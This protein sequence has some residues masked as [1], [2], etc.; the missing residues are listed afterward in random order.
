MAQKTLPYLGR[1]RGIWQR[2]EWAVCLPSVGQLE[3]SKLR[4]FQPRKPFEFTDNKSGLADSDRTIT[5]SC[6]LWFLL[7]I[8]FDLQL[9]PA[10]DQLGAERGADDVVQSKKQISLVLCVNKAELFC[11][12]GNDST[13]GVGD[14][15]GH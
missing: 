7:K 3:K 4:P 8:N 1:Q 12:E 11:T 15:G 2:G 13:H 6:G 10:P 9:V 14:G 5:A